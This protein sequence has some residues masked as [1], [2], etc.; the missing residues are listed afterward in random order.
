MPQRYKEICY[1]E[2]LR[3]YVRN[4]KIGQNFCPFFS[5]ELPVLFRLY[6]EIRHF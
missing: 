6:Q 1:V 5:P 2:S 3:L 4:I